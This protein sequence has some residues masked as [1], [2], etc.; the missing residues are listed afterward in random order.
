MEKYINEIAKLAQKAFDKK[1]VPIGAIVINGQ[2]NIIGRG[3]N[4]SHGR[5][6]STE[7]AEIRA[8]RQA[9][10]KVGDWRLD[11]CTLIV[12][13]EPCLMCLGAVANARIK[14]II[15]F[16]D[17]PLFGSVASKLTK[18]QLKKLFPK[19][20]IEKVKDKDKTKGLLQKFFKKL[21][22]GA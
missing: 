5:R 21:R 2:G 7:H 16:L 14:K 6:D 8:L 22:R 17:D 4:L 13:L 3:Y 9:F 19:L 20:E 1:E 18:K 10:R 15:Y 12:N 11:N